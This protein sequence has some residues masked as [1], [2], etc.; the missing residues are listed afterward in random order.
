MKIKKFNEEYK[1]DYENDITEEIAK[2][3][4][5]HFV[6][7]ELN[8]ISLNDSFIEYTKD[9]YAEDIQDESEIDRS[10]IIKDEL[11]KYCEKLLDN[12][13]NVKNVAEYDAKKFN[14]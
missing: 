13:K 4:I 5:V 1:M 8:G 12:A 9:L 3:I 2:S 14:L 6:E 11:V 7:N 10:V